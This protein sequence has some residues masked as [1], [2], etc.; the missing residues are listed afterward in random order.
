MSIS[1][2][3]G[4]TWTYRASP[5]PPIGGGQRLVLRRLK[6]GPLLFVA[7][8][9][10]NRSTPEAKGMT[11]TDQEGKEFT[12]HGMYAGASHSTTVKPG[13]YASCSLP[14]QANTTVVRTPADL[15][16]HPLVP[17][18]PATWPPPRHQTA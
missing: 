12:G 13:L 14:A 3:L 11:F 15:R 5:F 7:F 8:T 6:E 2:N 1:D 18:T 10:A 17:N 9:S 16:P 4:T